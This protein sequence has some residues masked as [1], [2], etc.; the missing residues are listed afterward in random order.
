[1]SKTIDMTTSLNCGGEVADLSPNM[2]NN[3]MEKLFAVCMA[4]LTSIPFVFHV[5]NPK[6]RPETNT[7]T[8]PKLLYPWDTE[9]IM[10]WSTIAKTGILNHDPKV[11]MIR[12]RYTN[13]SAVH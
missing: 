8:S 6:I 11:C 9:N 10:A 12:P 3:E 7:S 1:M 4:E 13:S 2:M 5:K